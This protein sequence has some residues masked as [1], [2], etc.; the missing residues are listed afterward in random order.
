[1]SEVVNLGGGKD[2]GV[3]LDLIEPALERLGG[4]ET[5]ADAVLLLAEEEAARVDVEGCE[6]SGA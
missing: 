1:M 3:K 5:A 6:G 2:L 4:S